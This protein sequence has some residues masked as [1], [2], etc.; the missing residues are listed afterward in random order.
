MKK[1]KS[2]CLVGVRY[3]SSFFINLEVTLWLF[4]SK[5][6]GTIV[7]FEALISTLSKNLLI[8]NI[9]SI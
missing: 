3:F 6:I 5:I 1:Q 7:S 8:F 9:D 4:I 2:E